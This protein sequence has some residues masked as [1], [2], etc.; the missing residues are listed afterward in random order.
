MANTA[1]AGCNNSVASPMARHY[2]TITVSADHP[3][4]APNSTYVYEHRLVLWE[5][6]GP[7]THPCHHCGKPVTWAPGNGT[8]D[9][10]LVVD[11]LDDDQTNN[12][13]ENL[14][15]SCITCNQLRGL[16]KNRVRDEENFVIN[17]STGTRV[18]AVEIVCEGCQKVFLAPRR[19]VR[20]QRFC[21]LSCSS[22]NAPRRPY[23]PNSRSIRDGEP[24]V[25]NNHGN[26][27]RAVAKKCE[28][29]GK[30]YLVV[31]SQA[32]KSRFCSRS[33]RAR[34]TFLR[35]NPRSRG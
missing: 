21:S 6:I 29:C 28:S 33:C 4:R 23:V 1:Q 12:R 27:V 25:V 13:V 31:K 7:G 16:R 8:S 20:P 19:N 18:R 26:R 14:A 22:R 17:T 11:H 10:C 15:P 3:L 32:E 35:N 30:E 24:F 34:E 9:G 5:H 2:R